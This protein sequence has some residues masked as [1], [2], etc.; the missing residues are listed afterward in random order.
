MSHDNVLHC[1]ENHLL[2]LRHVEK[3]L[4][5]K[6]QR[7]KREFNMDLIEKRLAADIADLEDEKYSSHSEGNHSQ[8][9]NVEEW[10]E[11]SQHELE[12]QADPRDGIKT[13]QL[14][15]PLPP[16]VPQATGTDNK[17]GTVHILASALKDLAAASSSNNSNAQMLSRL[18]TPRD[19]PAYSGDPLEWLQFK[20]AFEE[21]TRVCNF[22]DQENLWRLRKCLFGPA[23][24]AVTALLISATS[25]T[26]VMS[27]L[28]LQFGNPDIIIS[29]ITYDIKNFPPDNYNLLVPLQITQGTPNG[30]YLT[31]TPLGWCVHGCVSTLQEGPHSMLFLSGSGVDGDS[32]E[33]EKESLHDLHETVRQ[34]FSIEAMGVS[35]KPR[36]NSEHVKAIEHLERTS[37]L[38][39]ARWHVGLPWK[40]SSCKMP[41]SFKN[42]CNRLKGVEKKC[43]ANPSYAVRYTERIN[44]LLENDYAYELKDDKVTSKTWYL[45]HFGVDNPNKNKLRLV[46]DAAAKSNGYSLNDYLMTGPDLLTSL[47]GIMLRFREN[48]IAVTGD[49]RDMF[50][51]I[52]IIPEEQHALRFLWKRPGGSQ[53]DFKTYSMSSLIFG[54]NCSPFIAQFIKNKNAKLYESSKPRA[55]QAIFKQHYADDYIDSLEDSTTAIQLIKDIAHIHKQGGFEIRNWTSNC[56]E[57]LN[58]LPKQTLCSN[59]VRLKIGQ[60]DVG[61]RIFGL[62]WYP[63]DDELGFDVS[64]KR[65]P[66][67]I[68][69]GLK[70]PTKREML[71]LIMSIFDVYG[72]LSPFTVKAKIMLQEIWK[73]NLDWD[74]EIPDTVHAKWTNWLQQLKYVNNVRLPRCYHASVTVSEMAVVAPNSERPS[75]HRSSTT[76]TENRHNVSAYASSY[77]LYT[78]LQL[79]IFCDASTQAMCAV[80]YWRWVNKAGKIQIAFISSKCRV[81]PIKHTSVPRLELQAAVLGA[82][83]AETVESLKVVLKERA[84]RDEILSTLMA[85]VEQ[86]VN[87][88]P[89]THVSV[90]PHTDESLTPNHFLLHSSSN[91]PC[92]GVFDESDTY[93]RKQ[94]RI[95]Q[96][97]ADLFWKRWVREVLPDMRPRTKWHQDHRPLQVGDLVLIVDP[98]SSR[99]VWPRGKIEKVMPGQDGRVR[100]VDVRTKSGL[101]CLCT[102][103][104]RTLERKGRMEMGRY[105]EKEEGLGFFGKGITWACFQESGNV[106]EDMEALKMWVIT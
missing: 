11:R 46:F 28:E 59:A 49:I 68:I 52:K 53:G 103:R 96:R 104:S 35:R 25:P 57:V 26:V 64:F 23:K 16:P 29:K 73:T 24:E 75:G 99:N 39:D 76:V 42:A 69:N 80:A 71:R 4:S 84:P 19:L 98:N 21:S 12:A 15:Q 34:S 93:L 95:S 5:Y 55:V 48:K 66:E 72:F 101:F 60:Q 43:K 37:M 77:G 105:S 86:M 106:P 54:A 17:D 81:A 97:L 3:G 90:E 33:S 30:P 32:R 78:N 14:D 82:R 83:L 47:Y 38:K 31:R 22:S 92:I 13:G 100:V 85:E 2:P 20:Q 6:P 70:R 88:R 63:K 8:H 56:E 51:R 91:S 50:L 40:D 36:Q 58:S 27:T 45:P 67:N 89:L 74:D 79:H 1:L 87:S 94:W 10:L 61:E 7:Q 18:C 62:I 44:H 41:E 9:G 65:I 102:R